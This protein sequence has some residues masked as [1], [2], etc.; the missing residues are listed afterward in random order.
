VTQQKPKRGPRKPDRWR[1]D[2][3]FMC[4]PG[5][6]VES[7]VGMSDIDFR[8]GVTLLMLSYE[9]DGPLIAP[10]NYLAGK[11]NLT[12]VKFRRALAR[13]E[14]AGKLTLGEGG[15]IS[16]KHCDEVIAIRRAYKERQ[17]E[18]ASESAEHSDGTS[19][20]YSRNTVANSDGKPNENSAGA[21]A[22]R[23]PNADKEKGNGSSSDRANA[24]SGADGAAPPAGFFP[25]DAEPAKPGDLWTVCAK[26]LEPDHPGWAAAERSRERREARNA[27]CKQIKIVQ[28][29][30]REA[31]GA[32]DAA[33]ALLVEA[34]EALTRHSA[35]GMDYLQGTAASLIKRHR[36]GA[37]RD[38][39][40]PKAETRF[41][42]IRENGQRYRVEKATGVRTL[43]G[44]V[45]DVGAAA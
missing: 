4:F 35:P 24:L 42:V 1:L 39:A 31:I 11:C 13:L 14:K 3:W 30:I 23:E 5:P 25:E 7:Y 37:E 44:P 33:E 10:E 26:L 32:G 45:P 12:A 20:E 27:G 8:V 21:Q 2:E 43:I 19:A 40:A 22:Q 38:E 15:A 16:H 28:R 41:K 36:E 34:L 29:R 18:N 9:Q 6:L 17:A